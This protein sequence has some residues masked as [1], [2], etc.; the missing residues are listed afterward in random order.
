MRRLWDLLSKFSSGKSHFR[1][2]LTDECKKDL[3]W[4]RVLL[5]GW[6]EKSF[7]LQ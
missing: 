6:N 7:F 3:A 4:W 5:D 2:H 1:I